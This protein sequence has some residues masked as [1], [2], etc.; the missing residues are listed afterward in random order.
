MIV[1]DTNVISELMAVEPSPAVRAWLDK[2]RPDNVWTTA[3]TM[4]EINLGIEL[5]PNGCKRSALEGVMFHVMIRPFERRIL[6]F[7]ETAAGATAA[8]TVRRKRAGRPIGVLDA[9]IAGVVEANSA[10]LATRDVDDFWGMT[11]RVVNPWEAQ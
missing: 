5:M 11:F 2:Q 4:Y 8:L 9:Q 10:T 1:L 7:G 6:P 3:I